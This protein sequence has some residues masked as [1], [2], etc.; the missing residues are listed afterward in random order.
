[1]S[2]R[3]RAISAVLAKPTNVI[4]PVPAEP[5]RR[6]RLVLAGWIFVAF[7]AL[8]ALVATLARVSSTRDT[9]VVAGDTPKPSIAARR[10]HPAPS[11]HDGHARR[12]RNE[13]ERARNE[14]QRANSAA[15]AARHAAAAAVAAARA[16]ASSAS[17]KTP[18]VSP[19]P[20]PRST[21]APAA[22][23]LRDEACHRALIYERTAAGARVARRIAYNAATAGLAMNNHC[24]APRHDVYEAYL[25]ASRAP[26]ELA[27]GI[28][29][30]RRDL[31]RSDTLLAQCTR[32]PLLRGGIASDCAAQLRYN[33]RFRRALRR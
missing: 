19:T 21:H 5:R 29:D 4:A 20:R 33:E 9:V 2:S 1:M 11:S 12:A 22:V 8:L 3:T 32:R 24:G 7:G 17:A 25:L 6:G 16:A 30:W 10:K 27:L 28:G 15:Q 31:R 18:P 23:A 26:A 14:V 13:A